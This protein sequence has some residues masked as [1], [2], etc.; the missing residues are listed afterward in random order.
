VIG[1]DSDADF[2]KGFNTRQMMQQQG[3]RTSPY[4]NWASGWQNPRSARLQLSFFF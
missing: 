4:Y 1:F 2:F 3:I